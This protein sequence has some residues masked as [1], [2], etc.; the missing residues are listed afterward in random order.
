MKFRRA[1]DRDVKLVLAAPTE[2]RAGGREPSTW[3]SLPPVVPQPHAP[4]AAEQAVVLLLDV[5][6]DEP[7]VVAFPSSRDGSHDH[8]LA[9][10]LAGG[11]AA[12]RQEAMRTRR[13]NHLPAKLIRFF[14]DLN[15]A[16][17]VGQV[18]EALRQH[19]L[20]I[21][22]AHRALVLLRDE[23]GMLRACAGA[24]GGAD[25]LAIPWMERFARAGLIC[26]T[27][28]SPPVCAAASP[29]LPLFRE[30]GT[31]TVACVPLG[32]GGVLALTER[33]DE[34]IFEAEDW[35]VLRM[36][37]LQGEMAM[38]RC[39]LLESVRSLSLT[40]PLTGLANRRHLELVLDHVW[41]AAKRGD[42]LAVAILD[43][44]RFKEINDASGHLAGDEILCTV[45]HALRSE[46]RGADTVARYGGDEFVVV[47]PGG[48]E[49]GARVLIDRV[50]HRLGDRVGLSAG[51]AAY[52]PGCASAQELVR[53]A[54]RR[55]YEEKRRRDAAPAAAPQPV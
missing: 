4:L 54:D 22:G 30:K 34:R 18:V 35:D 14:E 47:L 12:W 20:G 8:A 3:E 16:E 23:E 21:V 44:D 11:P 46:A 51:V 36:L 42:A 29:L 27:E 6:S 25:T 17:T 26:V 19:A 24:D 50:R 45:A 37:S 31:S 43:L 15:R 13:R 33:R 10:R 49:A 48:D 40:D 52:E 38:K 53:A 1:E 28:V 55:L 5:E 41:P 7:V 9:R 2:W 39:Q 32:E